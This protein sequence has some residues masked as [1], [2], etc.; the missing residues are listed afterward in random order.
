MAVTITRKSKA[1]PRRTRDLAKRVL[2]GQTLGVNSLKQLQTIIKD[3]KQEEAQAFL[4]Y[5]REQSGKTD[6]EL[7]E[8]LQPKLFA[9]ERHAKGGRPSGDQMMMEKYLLAYRLAN[10]GLTHSQIAK[11]M[12]AGVQSLPDT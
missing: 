1:L 6:D 5:M 7:L 2:A 11:Q 3:T 8:E 9:I 4:T 10:R 12:N